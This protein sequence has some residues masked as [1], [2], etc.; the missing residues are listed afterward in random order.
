MSR[1]EPWD[2]AEV[3][4]PFYLTSWKKGV[5]C[6]G[7]IEGTRAETLF[8]TSRMKKEYMHARCDDNFKECPVFQNAEKKY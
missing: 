4:C 5:V 7:F 6:E 2:A 8:R 1:P 3:K